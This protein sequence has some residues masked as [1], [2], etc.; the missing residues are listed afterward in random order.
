VRPPALGGGLA[1]DVA[2]GDHVVG[3]LAAGARDGPG[4]DLAAGE[5]MGEIEARNW[6]RTS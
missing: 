6:P 1:D 5:L 3:D 4:E 2:D